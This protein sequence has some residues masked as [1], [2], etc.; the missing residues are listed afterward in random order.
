MIEWDQEQ[1]TVTWKA[2][3]KGF[4]KGTARHFSCPRPSSPRLLANSLQKKELVLRYGP[5]ICLPSERRTG[6][7]F[8]RSPR[9]R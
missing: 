5:Y 2:P 1:D 3:Q 4:Y 6:K 7:G 8:S 9:A